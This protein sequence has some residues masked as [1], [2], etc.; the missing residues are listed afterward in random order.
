MAPA[1]NNSAT[2]SEADVI[3]CMRRLSIDSGTSSFSI[4][5]APPSVLSLASD[6]SIA[7]GVVVVTIPELL[8]NRPT[9][10]DVHQNVA[11]RTRSTVLENDG[12]KTSNLSEAARKDIANSSPQKS[13]PFW[14]QFDTFVPEPSAP[15]RDEFNRLSRHQKWGKQKQKQQKI[16]ALTAEISFHFSQEAEILVS[17]Q[18]LCEEH[19]VGNDPTSITQ[20]KKALKSVFVNIYDII[21]HRRCPDYEIVYF[22]SYNAYRRSLVR[23]ARFPLKCAKQTNSIKV[24]LKR[25]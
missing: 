8:E 6:D 17:L 3:D 20:C 16:K 22:H 11:A 1:M 13:S 14:L 19:G 24:F 21:D 23:S 9:E 12:T 5:S 2:T 25:L 7:G 4:I 15:F 18:D 10:Q